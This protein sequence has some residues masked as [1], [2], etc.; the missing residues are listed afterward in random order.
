MDGATP[1][2]PDGVIT[3]REQ[4]EG[5]TIPL[6][7]HPAWRRELD[8]VVQGTTGRGAD[9]SADMGLFGDTPVGETMRR[10]RT[11]RADLSIPRAVHS[12]QVH[13]DR[14]L[15]HGDGPPGLSVSEGFDGH[16][17]D[18]PG[19]LLTV[20]V[21]DCVPI[22]LVDPAA[23]RIALLHGGWRG[24]ARRILLAGLDRLGGEIAD[25][26]IHLG[27]AIC[28][29]CYEV[30]PEVHEALGLP[31]PAGPTPVDVRAVLA[32]QAL[33]VGV[34]CDHI[35]ISE[36]CTRCGDGFFSHRAGQPG[37]Q[38]GVLGLRP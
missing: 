14:V 4:P 31:A 20:S 35:S 6:F 11:L 28:G 15:G 24:T 17:T 34:Q 2:V 1:R 27:P 36:H 13:E 3:V 37:R 25:I 10:W 29:Q 16:V 7:G 9:S 5:G 33:E 32:R 18:R 12:L 19:I 22:F 38:L 26:R 21:A 23:R 30:G 8:W